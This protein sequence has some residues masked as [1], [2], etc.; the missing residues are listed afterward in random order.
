LWRYWLD[1]RN[2]FNRDNIIP[3]LYNA[4]GGIPDEKI[5]AL[6]GVERRW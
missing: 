1:V 6:L 5:S 4:D 2:V 3:S